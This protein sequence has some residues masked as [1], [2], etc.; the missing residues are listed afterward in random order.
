MALL[1]TV[2]GLLVAMEP[3]EPETSIASASVPAL[4]VVA[5]V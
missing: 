2:I 5:P 3:T 1:A 4:M